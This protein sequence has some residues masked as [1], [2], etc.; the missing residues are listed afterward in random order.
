MPEIL[1]P[2]AI[3]VLPRGVLTSSKHINLV[4]AVG[5]VDRS[6]WSRSFDGFMTCLT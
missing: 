6:S 1:W 5:F 4:N 2:G 3:F